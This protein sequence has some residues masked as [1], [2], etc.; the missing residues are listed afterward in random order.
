MELKKYVWIKDGKKVDVVDTCYGSIIKDENRCPNCLGEERNT[1]CCVNTLIHNNDIK[2]VN[3]DMKLIEALQKYKRVTNDNGKTIYTIN[4]EGYIRKQ[5]DN[6]LDVVFPTIDI[7]TSKGWE[8]YTDLIEPKRKYGIEYFTIDT[9]GDVDSLE[10][11]GS[12]FDIEQLDMYN[13]FTN[14]EFAEY[15]VN[16][17]FILRAKLLLEH[18]NKDLPNKEK[19]ISEYILNN[20]KEIIDNI[21]E[22]EEKSN[23]KETL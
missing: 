23:K 17:Q 11:D 2:E 12:H 19:L 18:L 16:K 5:T 13:Y 10:D 15:V 20:H 14:R 9:Y 4:D 1:K 8:E 7:L 22:Y 6:P 21:K 3:N